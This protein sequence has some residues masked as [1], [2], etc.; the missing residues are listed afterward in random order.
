MSATHRTPAERRVDEL[1]AE[2]KGL[3]RLSPRAPTDEARLQQ[4]ERVE[5]PKA[6]RAV[7]IVRGTHER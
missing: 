5:I 2:A 4:L 6:W 7:H 3:R 1:S